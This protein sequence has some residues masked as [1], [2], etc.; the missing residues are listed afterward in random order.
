MMWTFSN[1]KRLISKNFTILKN[2]SFL[3]ILQLFNLVIPLLTYPYLINIL[4]VEIYG[5]VIMSQIAISYFSL[6]IDFGFRISATRA[7][8]I[9][10]DKLDEISK[11]VS[12][13]YIIKLGLWLISALVLLTVIYLL[14]DLDRLLL[15]FSFLICFNELLFPQWYFHGIERMEFITIINIGIRLF[16]VA[17]IFIFITSP[18]DYLLVPIFYGIGAFLGGVSGIFILFFK[19]KIRFVLPRMSMIKSHF[20]ESF[21]LFVSN[22]I[23][24]VKDRFSA[25]F[26]AGSLGMSQVAIYDF[27]TKIMNVFFQPI[28]SINAA[29]YPKMSRERDMRFLRKV[30]KYV[31]LLLV[32]VIGFLQIPLKSLVLLINEEIATEVTSL[33]IMLISP[34]I[35]CISLALARNCILVLGKN[36]LFTLGMVLTSGFYL[37]L[38]GIIYLFGIHSSLVSFAIISV[39]VY[40]FE[41]IYRVFVVKKYNLI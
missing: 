1:L 38:I 8:S 28:D 9:N 37:L 26:I 24:S 2:F 15:L 4:G 29:I 13:V 12:T 18:D 36:K 27:Y 33:R 3:T 31:F 30:T 7:I 17:L 11:I 41:L 32:L 5:T 25:F 40:L 35:L 14:S 10:R 23:I 34:L 16:F 39:L 6:I 20:K 22:A 19:Y 21:P